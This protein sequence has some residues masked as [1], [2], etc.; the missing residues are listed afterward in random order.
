MSGRVCSAC[1]RSKQ[2]TEFSKK[3]WSKGVSTSRCKECIE[4]GVGGTPSTTRKVLPG[5]VA[6][7]AKVIKYKKILVKQVLLQTVHLRY[8]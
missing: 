7:P 8:A 6:A 3:Q 2:R 4:R 1:D 5:A